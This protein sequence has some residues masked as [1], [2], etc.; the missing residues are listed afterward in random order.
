MDNDNKATPPLPMFVE[1]RRQKD[2]DQDRSQSL[3]EAYVVVLDDP[4]HCKP[5]LK[6]LSHTLPLGNSNPSANFFGPLT[7]RNITRNNT[8]YNSCNSS[9]SISSNNHTKPDLSH[10]KRVRNQQRNQRVSSN[11]ITGGKVEH[12]PQQQHHKESQ[13]IE[14]PTRKK[15]KRQESL[16]VLLRDVQSMEQDFQLLFSA[17]SSASNNDDAKAITTATSC[18]EYIQQVLSQALLPSVMSSMKIQKQWVPGRPPVSH[19][20]WQDFNNNYWPTMLRQEQFQEHHSPKRHPV[21]PGY[22]SSTLSNM[23]GYPKNAWD[24]HSDTVLV[25]TVYCR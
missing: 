2:H 16:Q 17:S 13:P 24:S 18:V 8:R 10:L 3:L 20:E 12:R 4:K 19:V 11:S 25:G 6:H 23:P 14:S 7:N 1:I 9:S 22:T 21:G 15:K 5:W